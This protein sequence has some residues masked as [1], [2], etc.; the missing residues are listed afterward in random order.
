MPYQRNKDGMNMHQFA[1]DMD[2]ARTALVLI[3]CQKEWL[4]AD[5]K[6]QIVIQDRP[7]F[8]SAAA[9]AL[10]LLNIA[11]DAGISIAHVGLRFQEGHP[12]MGEGGFGLRGAI[13]TFGTFPVNTPASEF[14]E[15]FEP[16]DNEFIV[17]GRVGG[18]A[19]SGSNLDI[20]LRNNGID[21]VILGGFALHV[22]V[23]SS[24]RS[25]HDL[26]YYSYL[27]QD[28]SAAFNAAQREHVLT[29]VVPHFGK[30]L[31]NAEIQ[32]NLSSK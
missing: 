10:E 8:D 32:S 22:C 16:K 5:G 17:T 7:Q 27:A 13:K 1:H 24:L 18:S 9:G 19:F 28:A 3:E 15:G 12:E 23:E 4:A 6:L 11:R 30:A 2:P 14:A 21:T 25:A 31:P 29:D 20:W 26:G